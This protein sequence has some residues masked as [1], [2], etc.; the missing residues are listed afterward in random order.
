[1]QPG[2]QQKLLLANAVAST[3]F[4]QLTYLLS[5]ITSLNRDDNLT[6]GFLRISAPASASND[7]AS[8]TLLDSIAAI[9]VQNHEVVAACFTSDKVAV[10]IADTDVI[11]KTD[12]E[13]PVPTPSSGSHEL[14]PLQL[15][16]IAN[17]RFP[18]DFSNSSTS[19][20]RMPHNVQIQTDGEN[21][22]TK[23]RDY[24]WYSVFMWVL[25]LFDLYDGVL[26]LNYIIRGP[27]PLRD[28]VTTVNAFLN[29]F[30]S[31]EDPVT[32]S[33]YS[34]NFTC[35]LISACW[36]QILAR[37]ASWQA[38]GFMYLIT[39]IT[40]DD[41]CSRA[42]NLEFPES[43]GPGDR[44]LMDFLNGLDNKTIH[45]LLVDHSQAKDST[46][47][48]FF[49]VCNT[50]TLLFTKENLRG[51]HKLTVAAFCGFASAFIQLRKESEKLVSMDY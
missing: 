35:Y 26:T 40:L 51:F 44:S 30:R 46:S 42:E 7:T 29:D 17:P 34:H 1:M 11:P 23:V 39:Q 25:Y 27:R 9:L 32:Q 49:R 24:G 15:A 14:Y 48:D 13:V 4:S 8:L 31:Q 10:M 36:P 12:I 45:M 6:S 19:K 20:C 3:P 16:A 18:S 21:V 2:E 33:H 22:W 5:L 43:A 47:D 28:H 41:F 38:K 37:I 50:R